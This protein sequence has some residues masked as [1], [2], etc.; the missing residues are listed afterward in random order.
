MR[1]EFAEKLNRI[2]GADIPTDGTTL[3]GKRPSIPFEVLAE[4][5]NL[6]RLIEAL[7]WFLA[8]L[9]DGYR[10]NRGLVLDGVT[11]AGLLLYGPVGRGKT[12]P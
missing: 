5:D 9:R 4:G 10:G 1:R 2:E 3:S 12:G 8:V 7:D 11:K 6:D